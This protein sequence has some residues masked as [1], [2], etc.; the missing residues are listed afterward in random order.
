[1]VRDHLH[2]INNRG[3]LFK[4]SYENIANSIKPINKWDWHSSS[5]PNNVHYMTTRRAL[6]EKK[7]VIANIKT[8]YLSDVSVHINVVRKIATMHSLRHIIVRML[9]GR[10]EDDLFN[11]PIDDI[12]NKQKSTLE[13]LV[14]DNTNQ[15]TEYFTGEQLETLS[16]AFPA[17][18]NLYIYA[19]GAADVSVNNNYGMLRSFITFGQLHTFSVCILHDAKLLNFLLAPS[20]KSIDVYVVSKFAEN[21]NVMPSP[22]PDVISTNALLMHKSASQFRL[23]SWFLPQLQNWI[24]NANRDIRI[25]QIYSRF[26]TTTITNPNLE[27]NK[28]ND[29]KLSL[30]TVSDETHTV[31]IFHRLVNE[32]KD[33]AEPLDMILP[34]QVALTPEFIYA[35]QT[36][37]AHNKLVLGIYV[38]HPQLSSLMDV[39]YSKNNHNSHCDIALYIYGNRNKHEIAFIRNFT[40]YTNF[41]IFSGVS[42]EWTRSILSE[43]NSRHFNMINVAGEVVKL[44]A[45]IYAWPSVV[46]CNR[47]RRFVVW[48]GRDDIT[49]NGRTVSLALHLTCSGFIPIY[50]FVSS[51]LDSVIQYLQPSRIDNLSITLYGACPSA[52]ILQLALQQSDF[53]QLREV[54][55]FIEP[56]TNI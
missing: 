53:P 39:L 14:V 4:F 55:I 16:V 49:M 43:H 11:V 48:W 30:S 2:N 5:V 27:I 15:T 35:L 17:L 41:N 38:D 29:Q 52:E 12:N 32:L 40:L 25:L 19:L 1:M 23:D 18:L 44:D 13:T 28:E 24:G 51:L 31:A 7:V 22:T 3:P 21:V 56:Y 8:L 26:A 47:T 45:H 54:R 10:V 20:V 36:A 33:A 34:L 42:E 50:T 37:L 9:H 46:H 6:R